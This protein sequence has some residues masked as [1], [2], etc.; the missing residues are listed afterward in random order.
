MPGTWRCDALLART[1]RLLARAALPPPETRGLE[2]HDRRLTVRETLLR[3]IGPRRSNS[4]LPQ[5][6]ELEIAAP[7]VTTETV[8]NALGVTPRAVLP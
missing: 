1:D 2:D 8:A 7:L 3:R 6:V 5:L 4:H